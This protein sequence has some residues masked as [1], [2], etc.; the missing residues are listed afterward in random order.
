MPRRVELDVRLRVCRS[1]SAEIA[2]NF[3]ATFLVLLGLAALA[4]LFF[5]SGPR[6][7][8]LAVVAALGGGWYR[9]FGNRRV[10]VTADGEGLRVGRASY[11]RRGLGAGFVLRPAFGFP[12][13]VHLDGEY[14]M[15]LEVR[16]VEEGDALVRALE[17]AHQGRAVRYVV[18]DSPPF[19]PFALLLGTILG[20][21]LLLAASSS[22]AAYVAFGVPAL[23]V[24]FYEPLVGHL[25]RRI[26]DVGSDGVRLSTLRSTRFFPL[27]DILSVEKEAGVALRTREARVVLAAPR[28]SDGYVDLRNAQLAARIREAMTARDGRFDLNGPWQASH[29]R[30][31]ALSAVVSP[32]LPMPTRGMRGLA[33]HSPRT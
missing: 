12:A 2:G 33:A 8:L 11:P 16:S 5:G 26:V 30:D 21:G 22:S 6:A 27:E 25:T 7:G 14:R 18:R 32:T 3:G 4:E 15:T 24:I 13:R 28:S 29:H 20:S 1:T 19:A 10:R 31:G 23:L 9:T 17:L